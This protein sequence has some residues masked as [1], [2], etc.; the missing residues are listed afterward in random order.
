L[1]TEKKKKKKK[2]KTEAETAVRGNSFIIAKRMGGTDNLQ[3]YVTEI[4]KKPV[5]TS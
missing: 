5:R 4:N 3:F 2:K 1:N